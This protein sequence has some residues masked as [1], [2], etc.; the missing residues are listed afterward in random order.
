MVYLNK[1][2]PRNYASFGPND[3]FW[4]WIIFQVAATA[5]AVGASSQFQIPQGA[6][7]P[8]SSIYQVSIN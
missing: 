3:T 4:I 1:Y 7:Y 2:F 8:Y 6:S 5:A